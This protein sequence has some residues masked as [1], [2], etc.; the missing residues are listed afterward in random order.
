MKDYQG[1]S[2][3]LEVEDFDLKARNR[4]AVLTNIF[5]DHS[6]KDKVSS[7]GARMMMEY[8]QE[9][10]SLEREVVYREFVKT[11]AKRG[12]SNVH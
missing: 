10:P 4:G 6:E 3:F 7:Q 1:Y 8:L 9:I 11:L 5:E 12:Y 2:L